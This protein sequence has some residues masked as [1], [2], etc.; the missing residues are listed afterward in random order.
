MSTAHKKRRRATL[1]KEDVAKHFGSIAAAARELNISRQYLLM[2]PDPLPDQWAAL[3]EVMSGG[4]LRAFPRRIPAKP[5]SVRRAPRAA[6][7]PPSP[8]ASK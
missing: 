3:A 8:G 5:G 6:T 4:K 1:R 2:M 7:A